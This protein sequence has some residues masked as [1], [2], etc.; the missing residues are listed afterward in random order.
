MRPIDYVRQAFFARGRREFAVPEWSSDDHN[1][2]VY[3]TSFTAAEEEAIRMREPKNSAEYNVYAL[4]LKAKDQDGKPLFHWG[5][6]HALMTECD[7]MTIL[8]ITSEMSKTLSA[9]EAKKNSVTIPTSTS[10]SP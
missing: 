4:I 6:K 9:E 5:D 3:F 8:T 7:Y 2:T 1:F 10:D